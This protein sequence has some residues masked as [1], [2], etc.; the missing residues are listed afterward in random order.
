MSKVIHVRI[1]ALDS[2]VPECATVQKDIDSEWLELLL[3][4]KKIGL[5]TEEVRLFIKQNMV[6]KA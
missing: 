2:C 3:K 5:S 1:K 4:A 6:Q